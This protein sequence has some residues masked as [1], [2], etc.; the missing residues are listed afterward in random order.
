[1]WFH[2]PSEKG[3]PGTELSISTS[4][5]TCSSSP[6]PALRS[7][8]LM[9]STLPLRW[10]AFFEPA[11]PQVLVDSG[12]YRLRVVNTVVLVGLRT[13]LLD[14]FRHLTSLKF[15]R[16]PPCHLNGITLGTTRRTTLSG[17]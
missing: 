11:P 4:S 3:D 5:H 1:M 14:G 7:E 2:D 15:A 6:S 8:L 16:V 12:A 17:L 9:I 13:R 10:E